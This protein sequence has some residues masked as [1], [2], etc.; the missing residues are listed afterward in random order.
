MVIFKKSEVKFSIPTGMPVGS[1][2]TGWLYWWSQLVSVN[3]AQ[4]TRQL[5]SFSYE[6][7]RKS[8]GHRTQSID[9][10]RRPII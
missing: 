4:L 6:G 9:Y 3:E 5:L 1:K 8:G 2:M 10:P 7:K